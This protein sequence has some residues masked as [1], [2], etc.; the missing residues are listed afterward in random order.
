MAP[1]RKADDAD[2]CRVFG[3]VSRP[4][5]SWAGLAVDGRHTLNGLGGMYR[6]EDGRWFAFFWRAPHCTGHAVTTHRAGRIIVDAAREAGVTLHAVQDHR[7]CSSER[8][9]RRLGFAPTGEHIE[10]KWAIWQTR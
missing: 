2:W 3:H 4:P 10:D 1:I 7:I 9:L 6:S 5:E 8:W